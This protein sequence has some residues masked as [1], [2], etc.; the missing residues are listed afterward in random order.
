MLRGRPLI[1][2]GSSVW[3]ENELNNIGHFEEGIKRDV[4][5]KD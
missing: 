5:L 1:A 2:W 3:I 4:L